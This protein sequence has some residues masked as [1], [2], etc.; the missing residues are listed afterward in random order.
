VFEIQLEQLRERFRK[1]ARALHVFVLVVWPM[2]VSASAQA[3]ESLY[4]DLGGM[5]RTISSEHEGY[6]WTKRCPGLAGYRLHLLMGDERESINVLRPDGTEHPLEFWSTVSPAFS[7]VGPRAE[8]R[9]RRS[10]NRIEP[11]ALIV[12]LNA[13]ENPEQRKIVSYL[14][15]V[16]L[17]PDKICVTDKIPP[18]PRA[19]ELARQAADDS[20]RKPCLRGIGEDGRQVTIV[21]RQ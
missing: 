7:S 21:S 9:I 1:A 5:C 2:A 3:V 6:S 12:R 14:V 15:V 8:W 11:F 20:T 4:T 17:A 19:N 16:R 13:N 10:G 18:G